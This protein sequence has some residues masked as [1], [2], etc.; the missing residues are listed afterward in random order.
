M[1]SS[2]IFAILYMKKAEIPRDRARLSRKHRHQG[3]TKK[4]KRTHPG[5][6][7]AVRFF[8]PGNG[9]ESKFTVRQSENAKNLHRARK[10]PSG[11]ELS[12]DCETEGECVPERFLQSINHAGSFRLLLRKIHLP[13]GGRHWTCGD[14]SPPLNQNLQKSEKIFQNF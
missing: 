11:R 2:S 6:G 5:F 9:G 7:I 13:P 8:A 3:Y 10:A 12:S 4:V 14:R 1:T